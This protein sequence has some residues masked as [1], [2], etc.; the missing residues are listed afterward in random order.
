MTLRY[1]VESRI[2]GAN[3]AL[4]A[5][6]AHHLAH[7]MRAKTGDEVVLFDGFGGEHVA[8]V[9]R[10][11]RSRV[12]LAVLSH[13]AIERE[14]DVQLVVAAPLPKGDRQRW[15]VEKLVEIGVHAL[16]PLETTRAVAQPT[17]NAI[18]RL[19]RTVIE[20]SK[21][22]GRNRLMQIQS[23]LSWREFVAEMAADDRRLIAHPGGQRLLGDVMRDVAQRVPAG[24]V[25]MAVGPEGGITDEELHFATDCGWTTV[26]L[27]PRILR[28][29][30]AAIVLAVAAELATAAN[31]AIG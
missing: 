17:A 22:C 8:A 20:A 16:V 6:E 19:R 13:N 14:L 11:D 25:T 29:E 5:A 2:V 4:V 21:Q 24:G 31:D 7:V 12:E 18:D 23:S 3:A 15:L 9:E 26:D 10:I 1:F 27:G 30:T 28:V